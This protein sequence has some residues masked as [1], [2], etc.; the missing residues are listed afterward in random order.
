[1]V[2]KAADLDN[3]VHPTF[4][5]RKV[6]KVDNLD[7]QSTLSTNGGNLGQPSSP[8]MAPP[9]YKIEDNSS[10]LSRGQRGFDP[11]S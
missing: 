6:V 4:S 7:L 3:L 10:K 2:A 8:E 1:M 11:G 5:P 9:S